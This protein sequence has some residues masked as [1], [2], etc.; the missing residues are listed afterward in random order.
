MRVQ[1][2]I[3]SDMFNAFTDII[4][5]DSF[6]KKIYSRDIMIDMSQRLA[7][8]MLRFNQ[9]AEPIGNDLAEHILSGD[10]YSPVALPRQ[11]GTATLNGTGREHN[12]L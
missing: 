11:V 3:V 9:P 4:D 12:G 6:G 10:I 7:A 8:L 5:L 2:E 1:N